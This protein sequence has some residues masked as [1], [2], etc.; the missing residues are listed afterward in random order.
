MIL[1]N[2]KKTPARE[3]GRR[4]KRGAQVGCPPSVDAA[5]LVA[6]QLWLGHGGPLEENNLSDPSET[7]A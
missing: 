7:W 6:R 3:G 1:K 4:T 5:N 2:I